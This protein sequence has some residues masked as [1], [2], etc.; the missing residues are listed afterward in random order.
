MTFT[1]WMILALVCLAGASSPGPSLALLLRTVIMHGRK[2]GMVFG[3]AHGLGIFFYAFLVA[4]GLSI[5]LSFAPMF[6]FFVEIGGLLFLIW[7]ALIMLKSSFMIEKLDNVPINKNANSLI[8]HAQSGFLIVFLNPKV[9]AF[10]LAIFTQFLGDSTSFK[11]KSI[12]VL[13]ATLIDA[14]WYVLISFIIALPI[15]MKWLAPNSKMLEFILGC[16]LLLLCIF[17]GYRIVVNLLN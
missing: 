9:A 4:F 16:I 14:G 10:F 7:L 3:L 13:T 8:W 6:I 12:M 5:T 11:S 2:A 17:L 1:E 15:F